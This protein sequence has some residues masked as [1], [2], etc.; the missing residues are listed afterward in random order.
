MPSVLGWDGLHRR[1]KR[2]LHVY[3]LF[4]LAGFGANLLGHKSYIFVFLQLSKEEVKVEGFSIQT[5]GLAGFG[6]NLLGQ[7]SYIVCFLQI[8]IEEVKGMYID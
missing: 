5:N 2:L 8:F 6:A 1:G 3:R 4:S 7:E